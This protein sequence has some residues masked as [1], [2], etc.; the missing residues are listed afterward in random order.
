[1]TI[2]RSP[3]GSSAAHNLSQITLRALPVS[4][5]LA[6]LAGR[7][8]PGPGLRWH[9]EYPLEETL[10][11]AAMTLDAH[12][13]AFDAPA[14]VPAWWMHQI[15]RHEPG[16]GGVV[17]G[18]VGFHSPPAAAGPVE[19]EIGYDVVAGR[20]GQGIAT[21]A[22]RLV[23]EQA[24][25]DGAD[26]VRAETAPDNVASQRVLRGAGFTD[27]GYFRYVI[28]RPVGWGP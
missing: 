20:R 10:G 15:V 19:V 13:I 22:C 6:L 26:V 17:V 14:A 7:G 12:R 4:E 16:W 11:A 28:E 27:L 23:L 1:M 25:R 5:A 3:R 2:E 21:R 9:P 8:E 24:W 18:D